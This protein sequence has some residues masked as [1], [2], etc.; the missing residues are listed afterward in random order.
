MDATKRRQK[1]DE[2]L[3]EQLDFMGKTKSMGDAP[4]LKDFFAGIR[5]RREAGEIGP[6]MATSA[7][8]QALGVVGAQK[9]DLDKL[10]GPMGDF[11]GILS[12]SSGILA[13]WIGMFAMIGKLILGADK[14][15]KDFNKTVMEGTAGFT[16]LSDLSLM[17]DATSDAD[18]VVGAL[19]RVRNEAKTLWN[20]LHMSAEEMTKAVLT[21]Q[22]AGATYDQILAGFSGNLQNAATVVQTYS[23]VT[24]QSIE[25]I[26]G[27]IADMHDSLV[28]PFEDME[29]VLAAVTHE[30]YAS[31]LGAD[32]FFSAL[33]NIT[34]QNRLYNASIKGTGAILE[35][36][37]K[38]SQVAA[39]DTMKMA[40]QLTQAVKGMSD[41][42][43]VGMAQMLEGYS[44]GI[45]K[46]LFERDLATKDTEIKE[47]EKDLRDAGVTITKAGV[48]LSSLPEDMDK[49]TEQL[50]HKLD[51]LKFERGEVSEYTKGGL[52]LSEAMKYLSEA[53]NME[54]ILTMMTKGR[55]D[56]PLKELA[57]KIG[58]VDPKIGEVVG[59]P[60]ELYDMVKKY[61]SGAETDFR[62]SGDYISDAALT[63]DG[64]MDLVKDAA[65]NFDDAASAAQRREEAA[66]R[67]RE[68]RPMTDALTDFFGNI[69]F[70]ISDTLSDIYRFIANKWED[71]A[72]D[73]SERDM[74]TSVADLDI[75]LAQRAE[76][77]AGVR[78][79]LEEELIGLKK[80]EK[81]TGV[82]SARQVEVETLLANYKKAEDDAA[83]MIQEIKDREETRIR[84]QREPSKEAFEGI[85]ALTSSLSSGEGALT[86]EDVTGLED[87]VSE[88]VQRAE[89]AN[90]LAT[91]YSPVMG[92]GGGLSGGMD[93]LRDIRASE[94]RE[95]YG[96]V[97]DI[98]NKLLE[99][100]K[101]KMEKA[102][103]GSSNWSKAEIEVS[104]LTKE[105]AALGSMN[106]GEIS[107]EYRRIAEGGEGGNETLRKL[108]ARRGA[109][110]G[111]GV[112]TFT[113]L[114]GRSATMEAVRFGQEQLRMYDIASNQPEIFKEQ[115][116]GM[117]DPKAFTQSIENRL[118]ASGKTAAQ[119]FY[120]NI[121][122]GE[123]A[124]YEI[125]RALAK[126]E[127]E[128]AKG[129]G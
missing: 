87:A 30:M 47:V 21:M 62:L 48:D 56:I 98:L 32:R 90:I 106:V 102:P 75:A 27:F 7:R 123:T 79:P 69:F 73:I 115:Y 126:L 17:D 104:S 119:Y 92:G 51:N 89:E 23:L 19:A 64:L 91:D 9:F 113:E 114:S 63:V 94:G 86:P 18:K 5:K 77:G 2:M 112:A 118:R 96:T 81:K 36:L 59:L 66:A 103:R 42:Q 110:S 41:A 127:A 10:S 55:T 67:T 116:A 72:P 121:Q 8:A 37:G 25:S 84:E 88:N 107:E 101:G 52:E 16:E 68:A 97:T 26:G 58:G 15:V 4:E 129:N 13:M 49:S 82:K 125:A 124:P 43:R 122:Q 93:M 109:I 71:F 80:Q 70:V 99:V 111:E 76:A 83:K 33:K 61:F 78:A 95:L 74:R 60:P 34:M 12:K 20:A 45:V 24:G 65:T 39:D 31:S 53:S 1:A 50:I 22:S 14:A 38:S 29:G 11:F 3:T 85:K 128:M 28:M 35:T 44:K 117:G 100:A 120:I 57:K 40:E 105:L 6:V 46:V 108:A 54:M